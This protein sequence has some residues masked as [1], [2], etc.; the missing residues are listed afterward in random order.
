MFVFG[1]LLGGRRRRQPWEAQTGYS[2][3]VQYRHDPEGRGVLLWLF[4]S[5]QLIR[6]ESGRGHKIDGT[7]SNQTGNN[8]EKKRKE[9]KRKAGQE[10]R[11]KRTDKKIK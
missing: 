4:I 10:S 8:F 5:H 1:C 11:Q 9:K 2:T 7:K 6:Y 3:V